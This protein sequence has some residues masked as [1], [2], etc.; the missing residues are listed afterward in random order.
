MV[1]SEKQPQE[2]A[3]NYAVRTL[4]DNIV[5]LQLLP[6]SPVS[7]NEVSRQLGVSRTPVREAL[8]QLSSMS[9]VEI[10]PQRGSFVTKINYELVEESRFLRCAVE[11][12]VFR[13]ACQ[14]IPQEAMNALEDNVRRQKALY[15]Q[16]DAEEYLR[17]DNEFHRLVF[18]AVGKLHA[19]S[20]VKD[21]M[22]HFDRIRALS[23]VKS[24]S[25]HTVTDHEDLL[26]AIRRQDA[27]MAVFLTDRHLN[28]YKEDAA[29]LRETF[30]TYF[31]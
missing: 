14:G 29:A 31:V 20:V 17:T 18:Q 10:L 22:V 26:Y 24:I 21:Q 23:L 16:A 19:Y 12:A 9:L 13:I 4:L 2:T 3:R 1:V 28:R 25:E 7:E 11:T 27:E 30:P 8:I 15:V 6:G 5:N